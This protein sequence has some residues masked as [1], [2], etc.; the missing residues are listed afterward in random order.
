MCEN[1][2]GDRVGFH[3]LGASADLYSRADTERQEG[4]AVR[5]QTQHARAGGQPEGQCAD[6]DYARRLLRAA[7]MG[8]ATLTGVVALLVTSVAG[9]TPAP[10]QLT[11]VSGPLKAKYAENLCQVTRSHRGVPLVVTVRYYRSAASAVTLVITRVKANAPTRD[12][13]LASSKNY[14]T[15]LAAY[16]A[17]HP[18]EYW[19]SGWTPPAF[20]QPGRHRGS[21]T[22]TAARSLESG[23]IN[24]QMAYNGSNAHGFKRRVHLKASWGQCIVET[25]GAAKPARGDARL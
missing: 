25:V 6:S 23:S 10:A 14:G 18:Y 13:K 15:E 17:G 19:Y 24:A 22:L 16:V 8:S 5:E 4:R 1:G 11:V 3:I 9:A 21:G 7:T 2:R 12:G 20:G